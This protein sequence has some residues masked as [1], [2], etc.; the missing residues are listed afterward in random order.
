MESTLILGMPL[1]TL[2]SGLIGGLLTMI[3]TKF[4]DAWREN[5]KSKKE[6]RLWIFRALVQDRAHC[7]SDNFVA[8]INLV[9]IEFSGEEKVINAWNKLR[10]AHYTGNRPDESIRRRT[11]E[12]LIEIGKVLKF[13]NLNFT[14]PGYIPKLHLDNYERIVIRD[15]LLIKLL[16]NGKITIDVGEDST[17]KK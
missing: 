11:N 17:D 1:S 3:L 2:S 12:L 10:D 9:E 15:D 14:D 16:K 4:Y 7:V 13:K 6:R 8:A 5:K